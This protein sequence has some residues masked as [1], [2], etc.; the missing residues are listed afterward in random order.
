[1]LAVTEMTEHIYEGI[2]KSL[3]ERKPYFAFGPPGTGKTESI[4]DFA[5]KLGR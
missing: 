5:M 1:M 2:F 4:K 3:H